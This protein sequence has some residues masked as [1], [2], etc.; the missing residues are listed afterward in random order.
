MIYLGIAGVFRLHMPSQA[1][2]EKHQQR[3]CEDEETQLVWHIGSLLEVGR[4]SKGHLLTTT[5]QQ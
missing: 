1:Y 3:I 5:M 4:V 2:D